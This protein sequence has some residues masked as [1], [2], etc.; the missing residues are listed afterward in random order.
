MTRSLLALALA[1]AAS[2]P[3]QRSNVSRDNSFNWTGKVP[4]GRWIRIRNLNG[5]ITVG[6]ASGD[7]VEVHGDK[8]SGGAAIRRSC[9]S[10]R[11]DR[12]GRRERAGVRAVG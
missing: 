6:Q 7:N 11:Q 1:A 2:L 3:P 10:R 8:A 5:S 4:A 9:E 12:P